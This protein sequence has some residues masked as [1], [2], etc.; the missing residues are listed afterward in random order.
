MVRVARVSTE[1]F[2]VTTRR[3]ARAR[4][5]V[6]YA[7]QVAAEEH[8]E[9]T[10]PGSES[11]LTDLESEGAAEPPPRKKRRRRAKVVE[12]VVYDIP[13]VETKTNTFKG[14]SGVKIH[15]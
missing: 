13:P 11:P 12:P 6:N 5:V 15:A 4:T 10:D 3:S 1:T 14:T 7:S 2:E 9:S 8:E